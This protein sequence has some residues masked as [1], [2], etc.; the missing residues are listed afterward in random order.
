MVIRVTERV[1]M[2][3]FADSIDH[4]PNGHDD[5][6]NSAMGAVVLCGTVAS[7]YSEGLMR[8]TSGV[9]PL[10]NEMAFYQRLGRPY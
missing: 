6:A 10:A 1:I 5:L 8:A 2:N 7:A 4:P 9:A 3:R